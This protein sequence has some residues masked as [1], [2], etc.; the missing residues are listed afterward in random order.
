MIFSYRIIKTIYTLNFISYINIASS[1]RCCC[2]IFIFCFIYVQQLANIFNLPITTTIKVV[3]YTVTVDCQR[4]NICFFS[5]NSSTCNTW[6][7]SRPFMRCSTTCNSISSRSCCIN[8]HKLI[9][10]CWISRC[11]SFCI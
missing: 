2:I 10:L 11:K 1:K 3:S 5:S 4:C 7:N 6:I 9:N 8:S